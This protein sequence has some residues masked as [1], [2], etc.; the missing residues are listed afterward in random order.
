MDKSISILDS[1]YLLW[2]KELVKRYRSSQIKAALKVN[3]EMLRFYWELG[4]DLQRTYSQRCTTQQYH[5]IPYR[6]RNWVC[7]RW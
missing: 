4:R 5:P 2:V 1:D 7:L 6:I 3:K